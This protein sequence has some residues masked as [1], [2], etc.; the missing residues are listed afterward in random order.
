MERTPV[1]G[2]ERVDK[3]ESGKGGGGRKVNGG[4]SETERA[5]VER[6]ND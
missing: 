2:D 5:V 4:S 1:R 6:V 3:E